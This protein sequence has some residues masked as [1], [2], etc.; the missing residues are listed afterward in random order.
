MI[1]DRHL[2]ASEYIQFGAQQRRSSQRTAT[3][4]SAK[5]WHTLQRGLSATVELFLCYRNFG[6]FHEEILKRN[7]LLKVLYKRA[8]N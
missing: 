7:F 5:N 2:R 4:I 3:Y 1:Y 6:N 8:K